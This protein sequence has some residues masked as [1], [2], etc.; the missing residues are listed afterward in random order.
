MHHE[1]LPTKH[2][3]SGSP[4]IDGIPP[5]PKRPLTVYNLFSKLE[6]NYI[7]QMNKKM[8]LA[9]ASGGSTTERPVSKAQVDPYLELRPERYRH[10][11][12]PHDWFKVGKNKIKRQFYKNHGIIS[13]RD[14]SKTVAEK[15]KTVDDETMD[16]CK[17][18]YTGELEEYQK[19]ME[20]YAQL[21]GEEALKAQKK[22]YSKQK[23]AG[24]ATHDSAAQRGQFAGGD[25]QSSDSYSIDSSTVGPN[26]TTNRTVFGMGSTPWTSSMNRNDHHRQESTVVVEGSQFPRFQNAN[27]FSVANSQMHPYTEFGDVNSTRYSSAFEDSG[28]RFHP[29]NQI[30]AGQPTMPRNSPHPLSQA[31]TNFYLEKPMLANSPPPYAENYNAIDPIATWGSQTY[32][33]QFNNRAD[34]ISTIPQRHSQQQLWTQGPPRPD[35]GNPEPLM[36]G[37]NLSFIPHQNQNRTFEHNHM[38]Q[39]IDIETE[40]VREQQRFEK[41]DSSQSLH[42]AALDLLE[43]KYSAN[44]T[45]N[46]DK[47]SDSSSIE[48]EASDYSMLEEDLPCGNELKTTFDDEPAV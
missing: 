27:S 18:V 38:T 10:L 1:Q 43:T 41:H 31:Q 33:E 37:R 14:L 23:S 3:T 35:T 34:A 28:S 44:N 47:D 8:S 26:F 19:E 7:V 40:T 21:Y 32:T 46:E 4:K 29:E 24:S 17:M 39:Y 25:S 36:T 30:A 15:W 9:T 2:D 42:A 12:L 48:S 22:T 45:E 20:M 13:F 5:K 16:F 6:R 11:V